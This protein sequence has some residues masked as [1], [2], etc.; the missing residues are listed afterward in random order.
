M[1]SK[2]TIKS[3]PAHLPQMADEK[4]PQPVDAA[5]DG[6]SYYI[7]GVLWPRTAVGYNYLPKDC[8]DFIEAE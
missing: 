7:N 1:G 3:V 2:E 6:L 5:W 8:A 4:T